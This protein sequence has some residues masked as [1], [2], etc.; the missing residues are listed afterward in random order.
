MRLGLTGMV[1]AEID[2][3]YFATVGIRLSVRSKLEIMVS[4]RVRLSINDLS[5]CLLI[6]IHRHL[7]DERL[8]TVGKIR[9]A[10]GLECQ[11][12]PLA[13]CP[14]QK[15]QKEKYGA[16]GL[17]QPAVAPNCHKRPCHSINAPESGLG[18]VRRA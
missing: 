7:L 16:E 13:L 18:S 1:P 2:H 4:V 9:L 8:P 11:Y 17:D 5:R 6:H 3:A 10:L 12:S 14:R 15:G